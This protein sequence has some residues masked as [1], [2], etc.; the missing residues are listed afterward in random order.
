MLPVLIAGA[1]PTGLALAL[2][3]TRQGVKVRV[4]DRSEGPGETSRAMAVHART[5]EFY[6]MCGFGDEAVRRG[7]V[8]PRI[9][10]RVKGREVAHASLDDIGPPPSLYPFVLSLPQDDH[11]KLLIEQLTALGVHV[12]RRTEL[13]G[14]TQTVDGVRATLRK[15]GGEEIADGAYLCGCDGAS[16]TVRHEACVGFPGG[17]YQQVFFVADAA[18]Q[19]GVSGTGLTA[20]LDANGFVLLLPVRSTGAYRIIG[21]VPRAHESDEVIDY[22]DVAESVERTAGIRV[23]AVNWFSHYRVH[24][25]V[26][27][28]FRKGRVFLLGDAGHIH[29]PAGGQ[30]LNTGVGDAV[31]LAWKLAA[32]V[33]GEASERLL[34][35]YEPERRG[36][37]LTLVKTTDTAFE[38]IANRSLIGNLW[39]LRVMPGLA[40]F[41][42]RFRAVRRMAFRTIS[43]TLIAYP[44]SPI[45]AGGAGKARAGERMPWVETD[46]GDNFQTL[47]GL[48][49]QVHVYG[50]AAKALKAVCAERGL[51]LHA[52]PW[53]AAASAAGLVRNALY[54][55]RPD[56][57]IGFAANRQDAD[58]LRGYLDGLKA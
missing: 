25:R 41:V 44:D 32:V 34:D 22:A 21:I 4:F 11:E 27:E 7:I 20:C 57:Y 50:E 19:S 56:G 5:L 29:S 9:G 28:Q 49:W 43:Q 37:A 52:F 36:F 16:S 45:S 1:G 17:T 31:N 23:G 40:G 53:S 15:D 14:F 18:I 13:T 48:A 42:T 6:R 39:R 55:L 26:A 51:A 12:E 38:F 47:D 3:L 10:F 30:G 54:L 33:K 2:F 8:N 24:H 58:G 35:S 46:S